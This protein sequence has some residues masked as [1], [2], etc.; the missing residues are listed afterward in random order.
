MG[1]RFARAG[2]RAGQARCATRPVRLGRH[3]G[4]AR[5]DLAIEPAE[6]G[7]RPAISTGALAACARSLDKSA[8]GPSP[9][10]ERARAWAYWSRKL[11]IFRERLG[12]FSLRSALASIWR[13]RSLVTLNC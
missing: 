4:E 2:Q 7:G 12:C 5:R 3:A 9:P 8:P 1:W 11:R 10:G 6:K 13:M